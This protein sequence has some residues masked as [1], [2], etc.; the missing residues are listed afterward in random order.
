MNG[1]YHSNGVKPTDNDLEAL[2]QEMAYYAKVNKR[3]YFIYRVIGAVMID[4][5]FVDASS[6]NFQG[7]K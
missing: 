4:G 1:K 5:T 7:I 6:P 3:N 2:K